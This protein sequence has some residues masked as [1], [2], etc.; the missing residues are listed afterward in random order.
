MD[1]ETMPTE[2]TIIQV[3]RGGEWLEGT[4]IKIKDNGDL[5]VRSIDQP[6]AVWTVRT[7]EEFYA[8]GADTPEVEDAEADT[9]DEADALVETVTESDDGWTTEV[10]DDGTR[11]TT[12]PSGRIF[13]T[14]AP[15]K[16]T[17]NGL[18][19]ETS[20]RTRGVQNNGLIARVWVDDVEDTTGV[21]TCAVCH[22]ETSVQKFPTKNTEVR[23]NVHRKCNSDR[24][25]AAKGV[26]RDRRNMAN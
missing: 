20:Y 18:T 7:T 21:A 8:E 26:T 10:L 13:V 4:V 17:L 23:L 24:L 3:L 5:R 9:S 1:N 15:D 11:I 16:P 2:G 6:K 12:S 14:V 22:E 25:A 19:A